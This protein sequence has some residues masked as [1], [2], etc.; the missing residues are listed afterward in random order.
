MKGHATASG[1]TMVSRARTASFVVLV[2][3]QAF[4]AN[5]GPST[6]G[7]SKVSP[8]A[9]SFEADVTISDGPGAGVASFELRGRA[10]TVVLPSAED[11]AAAG[12]YRLQLDERDPLPA[13]LAGLPDRA[14]GP[15]PVAGMPAVTFMVRDHGKTR[16]LSAARPSSDVQVGKALAEISRCE[17]AARVHPTATLALE[18]V[19]PANGKA[20]QPRTVMIRASVEG[21]RGAEIEFDASALTLETTPEPKPATPGVTPLPP[22]WEVVSQSLA[23][24]VPKLIRAGS[25]ANLPVTCIEEE[26]G[27]RYMRAVLQ[28]R[29]VLRLPDGK[30]ELSV[31]LSSKPVR[32]GAAKP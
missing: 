12:V 16:T 26:L 2:L 15:R 23:K 5:A 1:T 24:P 11:G 27:P 17:R 3:A 32:V 30:R 28:G 7:A 6:R 9:G 20:G 31:R 14:A 18:V 25:T 22:E 21:Q 8:S 29:S 13:S 4:C 19:P 10:L